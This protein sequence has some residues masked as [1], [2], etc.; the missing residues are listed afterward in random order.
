MRL[1]FT[2]ASKLFPSTDAKFDFWGH[3]LKLGK[4]LPF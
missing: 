4:K 2:P 1:N 3:V